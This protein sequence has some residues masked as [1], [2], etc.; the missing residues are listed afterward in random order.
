[1]GAIAG[2]KKQSQTTDPAVA[3]FGDG[4]EKLVSSHESNVCLNYNSPAKKMWPPYKSFLVG[5]RL[6]A[7]G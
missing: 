6:C 7:V 1:M 3:V 2:W 5:K 4:S